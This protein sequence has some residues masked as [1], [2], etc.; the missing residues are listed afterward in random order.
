[1][2][3]EVIDHKGAL[4]E[5]CNPF[6]R[7]EQ[8]STYIYKSS[9]APSSA[10]IAGLYPYVHR[11]PTYLPVLRDKPRTAV[12][13]ASLYRCLSAHQSSRRATCSQQ[14]S[15]ACPFASSHTQP[16]Q[17]Q[18]GGCQDL[19]NITRPFAAQPF[20]SEAP[21]HPFSSP[22]PPPP[23]P[24]PSSPTCIPVAPAIPSGD[25]PRVSSK[26]R[27]DVIAVS[28]IAQWSVIPRNEEKEMAGF[29]HMENSATALQRS[30]RRSVPV[31]APTDSTAYIQRGEED[32]HDTCQVQVDVPTRSY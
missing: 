25:V 29:L 4:A 27:W 23:P 11:V 8:T 17:L 3:L 7:P 30:F 21:F 28:F 24:S 32:A 9:R 10:S 6:P 18:I 22:S 5:T 1:M 13:R 12:H 31:Q 26:S 19:Q 2:A 14:S 20:S 16:R 15:P